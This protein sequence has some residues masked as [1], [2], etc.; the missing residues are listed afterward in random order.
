[1]KEGLSISSAI[2]SNNSLYTRS[3][4]YLGGEAKTSRHEA[5]LSRDYSSKLRASTPTLQHDGG[6]SLKIISPQT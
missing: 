4:R 5:L 2:F 6:A 3:H 1:M